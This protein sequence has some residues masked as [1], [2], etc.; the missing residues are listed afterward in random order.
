MN[1]VKQQIF[2]Q[3]KA[4]VTETQ[5]FNQTNPRFIMF[6]NDDEDIDGTDR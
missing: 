3:F 5:I 6:Y 1:Y 2:F 4:V